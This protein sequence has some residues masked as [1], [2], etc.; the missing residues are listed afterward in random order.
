MWNCCFLFIFTGG[1]QSSAGVRTGPAFRRPQVSVRNQIRFEP[2]ILLD[3]NPL[4]H[5]KLFYVVR[6][7]R[8]YARYI[9]LVF[10]F[11]FPGQIFWNCLANV[12][13]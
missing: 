10:C 8:L 7:N 5:L 9:L 6:K 11:Y 4:S 1:G 2:G 3:W 12:F 13:T